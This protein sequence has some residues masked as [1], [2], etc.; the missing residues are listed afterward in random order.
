MPTPEPLPSAGASDRF[1]RVGRRDTPAELRL[2]SILHSRGLRYRVDARPVSGLRRKADL[3]FRSARVAVFVDGCFWH[4]C[5]RHMAWPKA[6]AV[7]W[8]EKITRN[9]ERDRDTDERLRKA[10]W[11]VVRVWEHDDPELAAE[12]VVEAL[13]ATA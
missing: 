11:T 1:R 12:R 10:G 9:R 8:R 4:G 2:R 6:N 7:W 5:P 3:V 13:A